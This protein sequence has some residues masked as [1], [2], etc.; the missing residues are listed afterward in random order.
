MLRFRHAGVALTVAA[1][2]V[3]PAAAAS[4]AHRSGSPLARS[5]TRYL[6]Q[7][8][9]EVTVGVTD[10]VTGERI[11]VRPRHPQLSASIVKVEILE[12]LLARHHAPLQPLRLGQ[13]RRMIEQSSNADAQALWVAVGRARGLRAFGRRIGLRATR[14]AAGHGPGYAWGVTLTTPADQLRILDLLVARNPVLT[15]RDRRFV[16]RVMRHVEGGQRWG[17][18]GGTSA[19]AVTA[20]KDGWLQL[21]STD[22]QTNSI[23]YVRASH[24]RYLIAVLDTGSP[25]MTYGV[26]TIRTVS[27]I[28]WRHTGH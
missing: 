16:L 18:S 24:H 27:R 20:L 5:L 17:V 19:Q 26:R 9:G 7:R 12:S 28:V 4:A 23:G 25:T 22:W 13:A 11:L 14:P 10:L 21:G 15:Y 1:F 2:A 3:V 6:S 8:A